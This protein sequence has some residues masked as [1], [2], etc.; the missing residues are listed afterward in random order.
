MRSLAL[1]MTYFLPK[2]LGVYALFIVAD[3]RSLGLATTAP[4]APPAAAAALYVFARRPH[5]LLLLWLRSLIVVCGAA[6]N[7]RI[8][9]YSMYSPS[10][11]HQIGSMNGN[12]IAFGISSWWFSY[13]YTVC[14][15]LER[16]DDDDNAKND[17]GNDGSQS[18]NSFNHTLLLVASIRRAQ[19]SLHSH[20]YMR[21][22]TQR[23]YSIHFSLIVFKGCILHA[24]YACIL[25]ARIGVGE[26]W[27]AWDYICNRVWAL[28][29]GV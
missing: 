3:I 20:E 28:V 25:M 2:G 22:K 29:C 24:I 12:Q 23:I 9:M 27:M 8:H 13:I 14:V 21:S 5:I 11:R 19:K 17:H 1:Y 16:N 10:S 4:P 18:L 7:R 15:L 6:A 26:Y